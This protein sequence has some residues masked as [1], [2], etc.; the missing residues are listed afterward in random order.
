MCIL[1]NQLFKWTY[2]EE[3]YQKYQQAVLMVLGGVQNTCLLE[4]EEEILSN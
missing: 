3:K 4:H 2:T 1:Q